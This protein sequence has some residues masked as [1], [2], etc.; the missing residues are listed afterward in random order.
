MPGIAE[1]LL[2]VAAEAVE[3]LLSGEDSESESG[4]SGKGGSAAFAGVSI[5]MFVNL[6]FQGTDTSKM[7][8][9]RLGLGKGQVTVR[10]G[11]AA[12]EGAEGTAAGSGTDEDE[13]TPW[14]AIV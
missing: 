10:A 4:P 6:R 14:T 8:P 3:R 1:S 2:A 7:I 9:L 13:E 5:T 12:A 11:D